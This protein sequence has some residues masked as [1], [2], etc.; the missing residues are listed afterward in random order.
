MR[1]SKRE[2]EGRREAIEEPTQFLVHTHIYM[3]CMYYCMY[4]FCM[5]YMYLK[6]TII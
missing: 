4:M 6:V 2:G 5:S 3:Y 1:G